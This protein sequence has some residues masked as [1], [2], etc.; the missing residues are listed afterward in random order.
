MKIA[1]ASIGAMTL[2]LAGPIAH[3]APQTANR[4]PGTRH[5]VVSKSTIYPGTAPTSGWPVELPLFDA[6]RATTAASCDRACLATLADRYLA[7]LSTH[8]PSSLPVARNVR[9]TENGQV[10]RLGDGVWNTV[11]SLGSYRIFVIDPDSESISMQTVANDGATIVQLMVRLKT[12]GGRITE[13]ET[14]AARRGDSCCWDAERLGGLAKSY[15][16]VVPSSE[17]SSRG[18]L[19][20]IADAYFAALH[21]GGTP[22]YRTPPVADSLNRFEN[23]QQSTNVAGGNRITRLTARLQ[24]DSASV[25]PLRVVHR[26]YPV[27]DVETGTVLGIVLFEHPTTTQPPA[28]VTEFFRIR[29]GRIQEIRAVLIR[30]PTTG[31]N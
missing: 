5:L 31:W 19:I 8:D 15:D 20:A 21:A 7:L 28:I 12:S 2:V 23:G 13:I 26:R 27:V 9:V 6:R 29:A 11:T 4:W 3:G 24:L 17:R 18:E 22:D 16:E 25:G 30:R 1:C 10:V 14:V